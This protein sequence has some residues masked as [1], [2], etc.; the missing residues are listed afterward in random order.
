MSARAAGILFRTKDGLALFLKRGDGADDHDGE[1]CTPGGGIEGDETPAQAASRETT[2]ETGFHP[3]EISE[4][5]A[6][7]KIDGVEFSTFLVEEPEPFDVVLNGEHSEYAWAP[8]DAPPEPLHPGV[9]AVLDR[10]NAPAEDEEPCRGRD[11]VIGGYLFAKG[12]RAALALDRASVR[13]Y[14]KDGRLHVALTPISKANVCPYFGREIPDA[15]ALGLNPDKQYLLLRDPEELR[16]AAKTFNNLPLLSEHVPVSADDHQP[17]LVVGSIGTDAVFDGVYLRNSLVVWAK[18][19]I[20]AI[21]E[22]EQKELSSA[23]RYRAD[24]TPGTYNGEH[25]DGVM[26]DIEGNH[27]ALVR[28]GR[29]GPDVVVGDSKHEEPM[30]K[31]RL[32]HTG[33][34]ARGAVYAYLRPKIAQ[35]AKLSIDALFAG[36]TAKNFADRTKSIVAGVKSATKGKLAQDA[37]IGDLVQLLDSLAGESPIEGNADVEGGDPDNDG[38]ITVEDPP[39]P[40]GE[41]AG[42]P[43]APTDTGAPGAEGEGGGDPV[44]KIKEF[45]AGKLSEEDMAALEQMIAALAQDEN[46]DK[47]DDGNPKPGPDGAADEEEEDEKDMVDKKAMDAA[48]AAAAKSATEAANRTQKEIRDAERFVRPIVGDLSIAFDSAEAVHR[49]ALDALG[50]KHRGV[51]HSALKTMIEMAADKK[52]NARPTPTEESIAQDSAASKDFGARF[53]GASRIGFA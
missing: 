34:M 45:L 19:A 38:G 48:I 44:A 41:G 12:L 46:D 22:G 5:L 28:E 1:W 23:Y 9:R 21:E 53:P 13:S 17:D 11:P 15:E 8:I 30:A 39:A 14:D 29:A 2:E 27:V 18:E 50:V 49:A 35:D 4:P 37:D 10:L 47:D 33:A 16:R 52:S 7:T 42:D 25:Y 40:A 6:V 26:R 20:S 51:H 24:M 36:V 31:I 32:T 43:P 3:P